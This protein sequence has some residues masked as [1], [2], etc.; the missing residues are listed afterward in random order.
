MCFVVLAPAFVCYGFTF[1]LAQMPDYGLTLPGEREL[2]CVSAI[3]GNLF[4]SMRIWPLAPSTATFEVLHLSSIGRLSVG[5]LD[6]K[7]CLEL[8]E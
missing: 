6:S 2:V 5:C 7:V 8:F 4:R 3:G 1:H